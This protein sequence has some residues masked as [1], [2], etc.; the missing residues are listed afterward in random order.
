[1]MPPPVGDASTMYN[2]GTKVAARLT[3]KSIVLKKC[4]AKPFVLRGQ[5]V[6][7]LLPTCVCFSELKTP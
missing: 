6:Q 2:Q 1:M 5:V 7:P 3:R 4:S